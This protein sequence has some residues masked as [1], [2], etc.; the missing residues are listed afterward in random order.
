MNYEIFWGLALTEEGKTRISEPRSKG[1]FSAA[2]FIRLTNRYIQK[3][4]Q[5]YFSINNFLFVFLRV[6]YF[7]FCCYLFR[8]CCFLFIAQKP[9]K[10]YH[11]LIWLVFETESYKPQMNKWRHKIYTHKTY[12]RQTNKTV[13]EWKTAG[14]CSVC[15]YFNDFYWNKQSIFH[16]WFF[17]M[18]NERSAFSFLSLLTLYLVVHLMSH[19]EELA[20]WIGAQFA[21][22]M[23]FK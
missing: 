23:H 14:I 1:K 10:G 12:N 2:H 6:L 8:F 18:N 21:F 5:R 19:L 15:Y 3:K 17:P 11:K 9:M 22:V 4:T 20:E 16:C 13:V 7:L